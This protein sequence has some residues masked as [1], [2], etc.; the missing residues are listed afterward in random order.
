[1]LFSQSTHFFSSWGHWVTSQ[2]PASCFLLCRGCE[3]SQHWHAVP[4]REPEDSLAGLWCANLILTP[5][6]MSPLSQSCFSRSSNTFIILAGWNSEWG[7][8]IHRESEKKKWQKTEEWWNERKE[9]RDRRKE[10]REGDSLYIHQWSAD[11]KVESLIK[12]SLDRS[13]YLFSFKENF[14]LPTFFKGCCY[15]SLVLSDS[16]H[17]EETAQKNPSCHMEFCQLTMPSLKPRFGKNHCCHS[18]RWDFYPQQGWGC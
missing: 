2:S 14:T 1:M 8:E 17:S 15:C 6:C 5:P 13:I 9:E 3:R 16:P 7:W 18:W 10:K 4:S 12:G 11:E